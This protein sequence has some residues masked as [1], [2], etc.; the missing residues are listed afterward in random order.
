MSPKEFTLNRFPGWSSD[1]G[2]LRFSP[3]QPWPVL[4]PLQTIPADGIW[5]RYF[6]APKRNPNR[7]R[8]RRA[9]NAGMIRQGGPRHAG[10]DQ[11]VFVGGGGGQ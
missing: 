3:L 10:R 6:D 8:G 11:N 5:M 9:R 2:P 1:D 4:A 7:L